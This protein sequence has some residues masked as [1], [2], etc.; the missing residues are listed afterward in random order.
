MRRWMVFAMLVLASLL[1]SWS[2]GGGQT[3]RAATTSVKSDVPVDWGTWGFGLARSGYNPFERDLTTTTVAGLQQRWTFDL[4]AVVDTQP[5]VASNLSVLV[6]TSR[7]VI[8]PTKQVVVRTFQQLGNVVFVGSEHGR[9]FAVNAA[10]GQQIWA[11][12]LGDS[13]TGCQQTPD[14][15]WG[16]TGAPALDRTT[17]TVYVAAGNGLVYA[18]DMATGENRPGW[19]VRITSDP[20]HEHVWGALAASHDDLYV[21]L[22][23]LCDALPY[24]GR[25]V[26]ISERAHR[27]VRNWFVVPPSRQG[28]SIWGWGGVSIDQN[29]GQI[30]AATGNSKTLPES[31]GFAEHVVRLGMDLGVQQSNYPG[32]TGSDVDFG[33]TPMLYQAPGCRPQLTVMNKS[34]E[35]FVYNR[36]SISAGPLQTMVVASPHQFIGVTAYDP[37]TNMVYVANPANRGDFTHGLVAFQVNSS[38][39]L[40]R[41]WQQEAGLDQL[42]TST[43]TVAGDVV[44]YGDGPGN[45]VHAFN[46]ATGAPL[47]DS[48][49]SIQGAVFAAPTVVNG[50]LFAASRDGR[51]HAY[52]TG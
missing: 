8:S 29:A 1:L 13:G 42:P 50:W 15:R 3:A 37:V 47:W 7:R 31:S 18:L 2:A 9:F 30:F 11:R 46:A 38:C 44:Y 5:I 4:H 17:G 22:A 23:G 28:G 41:A 51:L 34:G 26:K 6:G 33:S 19:P 35:L 24:H 21:P 45:R 40:T 43:P 20:R 10:T 14:S 49:N 12:S 25:L 48:G 32:L 36:N 39:R 27:V 16:I 52:T